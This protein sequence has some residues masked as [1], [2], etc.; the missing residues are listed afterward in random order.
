MQVV[1]KFTDAYGI[2]HEDAVFIITTA[3]KSKS[4]S[5]TLFYDRNAKSMTE[6][7]NV[8]E[9]INYEVS[10][11]HSRAAQEANAMLMRLPDLNATVSTF[12]SLGKEHEGKGVIEIA[13]EHF[14]ASVMPAINAQVI[15]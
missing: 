11:W 9:S 8:S 12:V 2:N 14:K 1:A 15:E 3:S 13:I 5:T 4:E 10:F 7:V 6:T